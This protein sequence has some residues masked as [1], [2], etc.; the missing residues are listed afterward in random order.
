MDLYVEHCGHL[1]LHSYLQEFAVRLDQF[2]GAPQEL[3]FMLVANSPLLFKKLMAGTVL[4]AYIIGPKSCI[5]IAAVTKQGSFSPNLTFA[6]KH[7]HALY[8]ITK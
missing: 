5:D 8:C 2:I 6:T 3:Q 4:L 7:A 1:Q